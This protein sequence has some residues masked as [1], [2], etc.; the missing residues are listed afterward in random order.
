MARYRYYDMKQLMMISVSLEEQ[1]KPGTL[2]Y[3]IHYRSRSGST[4]GI[5]WVVL[6]WWD[7]QVCIQSETAPEGCAV[8][9]FKGNDV[10]PVS[11]AGLR[12]ECHLHRI[13]MRPESGSRHY[14]CI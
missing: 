11:W 13:V 12:K 5:W 3:A 1:L 9:V 4:Q 10:F 7:R 14:S 8:W 6:Q 2:G